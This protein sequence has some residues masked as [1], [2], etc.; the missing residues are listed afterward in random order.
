MIG[1]KCIQFTL[2]GKVFSHLFSM[3]KIYEIQRKCAKSDILLFPQVVWKHNLGEAGSDTTIQS[4][5]IAGMP[6][7]K[8][9]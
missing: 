2:N 1:A 6:Q 7:S 9:Y 5:I 4:Q 3:H 8:N